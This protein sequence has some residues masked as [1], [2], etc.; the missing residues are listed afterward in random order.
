MMKSRILVMISLLNSG[1][2]FS[3]DQPIP[4]SV[5]FLNEDIRLVGELYLPTNPGPHPTV[6]FTHGSG[7]AGRDNSRYQ[8]EATYFAEQGIASLVFDK[9]GYGESGGDWRV[10]SFEDLASD[11]VAAVDYLKSRNDIDVSRLGLRG[12]SQSG[13]ILPLAAIESADVRYLILISPAGMTPYDQ[14]LYDV[15]TDV[16]DAG[17]SPRDAEQALTVIESGLAYSRTL[18][19]WDRHED[20]LR[21]FE[22]KEWLS[23]ASGPPVPDH[24]MWTWIR[25]LLDFD[26]VPIAASL[27]IPVLVILGEDDREAASQVAGF[28]FEKAFHDSQSKRLVRYFPNA[29]HSLRTTVDLPEDVRPPIVDGYLET[30]RDWILNSSNQ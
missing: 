28:R 30:M 11:A 15:R 16:E 25:P 3:Q 12:A 14:I 13:W 4:E 9:R 5:Y 7:G 17:F 19:N 22:G 20:V 21:N 1:A 29:S 18:D 8:L 2:A 23:I 27:D 10:A 6:I 26:S 24:W